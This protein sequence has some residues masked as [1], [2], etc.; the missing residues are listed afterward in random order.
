MPTIAGRF[1][2]DWVIIPEVRQIILESARYRWVPQVIMI[3]TLCIQDR[4]IN[5]DSVEDVA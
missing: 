1:D 4:R 2:C 3:V 5:G